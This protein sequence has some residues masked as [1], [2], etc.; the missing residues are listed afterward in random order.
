MDKTKV[1]VG[2]CNTAH[3]VTNEVANLKKKKKTKLDGEDF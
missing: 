3:L 1:T 2:N